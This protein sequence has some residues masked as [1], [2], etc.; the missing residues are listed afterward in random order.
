MVIVPGAVP[1]NEP[2]MDSGAASGLPVM[3]FFE[4]LELIEP[5]VPVR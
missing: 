5:S 4:V 3:Y 2:W 1:V